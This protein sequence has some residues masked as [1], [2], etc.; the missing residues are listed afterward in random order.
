MTK[1]QAQKINNLLDALDEE[2]NWSKYPMM[3]VLGSIMISFSMKKIIK[4][5]NT[6]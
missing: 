4:A 5:L 1:Q 2:E 6:N 3:V